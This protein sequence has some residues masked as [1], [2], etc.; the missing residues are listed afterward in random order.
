MHAP[1]S[2][3][4]SDI[5]H[6]A[7]D[8]TLH[9]LQAL[10]AWIDWFR[11]YVGVPLSTEHQRQK[12]TAAHDRANAI[13]D[14]DTAD[15]ILTRFGAAVAAEIP[16]TAIKPCVDNQSSFNINAAFAP[17]LWVIDQNIISDWWQQTSSIFPITETS[18]TSA[19]DFDTLHPRAA[20]F[21]SKLVDRPVDSK[22]RALGIEVGIHR[23]GAL[24]YDSLRLLFAIWLRLGCRWELLRLSPV[25]VTS[26][27]SAT[28]PCPPDTE[29]RLTAH[30]REPL[31]MLKRFYD[32][33]IE[34]ARFVQEVLGRG[35]EGDGA[36]S[37]QP[38]DVVAVGE[39]VEWL[40]GQ[41][42][43]GEGLVEQERF[44]RQRVREFFAEEDE[45]DGEVVGV[46]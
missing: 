14:A 38:R 7:A 27:S 25:V 3:F 32:E 16:Y 42:F 33:H 21:T 11:T 10:R 17:L 26:H 19:Q 8:G 2:A 39:M 9:F 31:D 1:R 46:K 44:V 6:S 34:I 22:P 35:C 12:F 5:P 20:N 36:R 30:L 45:K 13:I 37:R 15:R 4:R 28:K 29:A 43:W 23:S 18:P 40:K 24:D 41:S